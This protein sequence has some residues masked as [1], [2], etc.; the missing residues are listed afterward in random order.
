MSTSEDNIYR[1][2]DV[3][4]EHG[5]KGDPVLAGVIEAHIET[6]YGPES[7]IWRHPLSKEQGSPI[8][9]RLVQPTEE[10]PFLTAITVG[11]SERPMVF[12]DEEFSCELV[13]VLP[14]DWPLEPEI[15]TWPLM[16]LDQ[17]A[18]FPHEY[19]TFLGPGNTIQNP[20]PWSPCGLNGAIIGTQLLAPSDEATQLVHEGR[21]IELLAPWL[22][23]QDEMQLKFDHGPEHLL[24]ACLEAGVCEAIMPD[25]PSFAPKRRRRFFR[26]R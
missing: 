16:A 20:Y 13:M 2:D 23:Y 17:L 6:H 21:E 7:T 25:R 15:M 14:P 22:L 5:L 4:P 11:M 8:F 12:E 26:R 18:H 24:D 19:K 9:L 10:R 3:E 1:Y